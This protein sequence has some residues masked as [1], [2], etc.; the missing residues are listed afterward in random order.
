VTPAEL[1]RQVREA[2]AYAARYI[3]LLTENNPQATAAD[4]LTRPDVDA[5][6]QQALDTGRELATDAVREGWGS[7]PRHDYLDWLLTDVD[8]SY[9]AL[10]MLRAEI[11]ASW[12]SVPQARF[13]PGS[14]P[15]TNP[16]MAAARE[17]AQA[18]TDAILGHGS[19]IALRNRLSAEVAETAGRTHTELARGGQHEGMVWKQW[20]CRCVPHTDTPD[21]R[22][23]HWCRILHGVVIPLHS[24]FPGGGAADLTGH[25]HLTR[26]PKIYHGVL[27]GPPRHPRCRCRIVI[28]TKLPS[29]RVSSP[30]GSGQGATAA[31]SPGRGTGSQEQMLPANSPVTFLAAADIRDMPSTRYRSMV[32]FLEAAV[33]ELGQVL[34]R[35]RE[36]VS[37]GRE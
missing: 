29:E 18:V 25:G 15:G 26:P 8:R 34:T 4:I 3:A 6:L 37:H 27:Q 13:L 31:A 32:A 2:F 19:G 12:H 35:L 23:C 30:Q 1:S 33:H 16:A 21:E 17:R 20:R 11:R 22:V 9:D 24:N 7:S 5:I 28:L 10:A 36:A 14:E